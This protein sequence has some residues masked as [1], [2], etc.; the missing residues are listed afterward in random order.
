MAETHDIETPRQ[1]SG[2]RTTPSLAAGT[3]RAMA[4]ADERLARLVNRLRSAAH[5]SAAFEAAENDAKRVLSWIRAKARE[6]E[7]ELEKVTAATRDD[8]KRAAHTLVL[9][10]DRVQPPKGVVAVLE[11]DARRDA[12]RPEADTPGG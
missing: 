8:F 4:E 11:A 5:G 12:D 3:Q 6:L 1:E 10:K 2:T 7:A 9:R